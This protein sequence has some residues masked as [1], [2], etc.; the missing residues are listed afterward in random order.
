MRLG[1]DLGGTK[2]EGVLLSDTGEELFRKRVDTPD[3]D[4]DAILAAVV[5]LVNTVS[6]T[7]VGDFSVGIGTPGSVSHIDGRMKN[8]NSTCLNGQFFQQDLEQ[9][10]GQN[11]RLAN[12]ANCFALSEA[13][14]GAGEGKAIVFG[15]ILGTG[16]GG[17]VVIN[18]QSL[19]GPNTIG[20]EWGHNC[21]PG[22][23]IE[24]E[25]ERRPCYCGREN[26]IETY[27]SG[28]G[29]SKT[30]ERLAGQPLTAMQI[31]TMAGEGNEAALSALNLYQQQLAFALSQVI[32]ILDPDIIV[33][34]GGLSNIAS[35][36]TAVPALLPDYVF[37]DK[38]E[39][40]ILP[41]KFGD[42]SGVR[43]AAWL[44]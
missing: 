41:A 32:N 10:L 37:S 18:R 28:S 6:V 42:S 9:K 44:W 11:I 23:G 36:Y 31:A 40:T 27:L 35:L 15:V 12:D 7:S 2:I 39:T 3:N 14:D 26:C 30:F 17:G 4:Y 16:V 33:L 24:F 38:V 1:I 20:S 29:L 43:G 34:G 13:I 22:V 25:N 19:I 8:C 5:D 21:L